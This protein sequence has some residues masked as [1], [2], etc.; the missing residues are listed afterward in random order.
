MVIHT[1][2][3]IKYREEVKTWQ[4]TA[5]MDVQIIRRNKRLQ[6]VIAVASLYARIV[7]RYSALNQEY[8]KAG[9]FVMIVHLNW[10]LQTWQTLIVLEKM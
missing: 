7:P 1:K 6:R 8:I 5:I 4:D 9:V 3:H 10:S 2:S